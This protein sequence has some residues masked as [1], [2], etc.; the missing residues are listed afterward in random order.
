MKNLLQ[1]HAVTIVVCLISALCAAPFVSA[2]G[3][4]SLFARPLHLTREIVDPISGATSRVDEYYFANRAVT[5]R[6]QRTVIADYDR[7]ELTEIDRAAATYSVTS[8]VDVAG[9]GSP[10]ATTARATAT[11]PQPMVERRGSGSR[12]GRTVDLF[13]S[14]TANAPLHAEIAVAPDIALSSD[15]FDVVTGAAHPDAGGEV[16]RLSRAAARRGPARAQS[17]TASTQPDTYGLPLD[18]KLQWT[19]GGRS[20]EMENRVVRVGDEAVPPDL[21]AIPPGAQRVESQRLRVKSASEEIDA[22]RP[23]PQTH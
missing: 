7:Q 16:A 12:A 5:V 9:A 14:G 15:A 18:L 10:R 21:L 13:E 20:I 6:G 8:F 11:T 19:E 23:A 4:A 2:S 1:H 3:A 22:I 17:L